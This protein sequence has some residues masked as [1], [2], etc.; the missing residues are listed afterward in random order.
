METF[1][2]GTGAVAWLIAPTHPSCLMETQM[3][4]QAVHLRLGF[5]VETNGNACHHKDVTGRICGHELQG[6]GYIALLVQQE[7]ALRNAMM[8]SKMPVLD[9]YGKMM[10]RVYM[11]KF[12]CCQ[13]SLPS[14]HL[15][16]QLVWTL[17]FNIPLL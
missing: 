4:T 17:L 11:L 15:R 9:Y 1:C 6:N 10:L 13:V 3:F 2:S 5:A 7:V 8:E 12:H 14:V 16:L